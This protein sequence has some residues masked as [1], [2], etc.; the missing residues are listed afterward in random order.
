[1]T[2]EEARLRPHGFKEVRDWDV[3]AAQVRLLKGDKTKGCK[4]PTRKFAGHQTSR[5]VRIAGLP[6]GAFVYSASK[7]GENETT[8]LFH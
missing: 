7:F 5:R 3:A 6:H 1:V 2:E 4:R 8:A